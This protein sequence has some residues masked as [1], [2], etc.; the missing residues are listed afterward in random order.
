MKYTLITLAALSGSAFA[1]TFIAANS[2]SSNVSDYYPVNRLISDA[3]GFNY[4]APNPHSGGGG[5][6]WWT[7]AVGSTPVTLTFDFNSPQQIGAVGIWDYA[8][9]S[10]SDWNIKLF[11][12]S[13]GTGTA[14]LDQDF[15]LTPNSSNNVSVFNGI[16]LADTAGVSSVVLT[17]RNDGSYG[18]GL[19]EVYFS[20]TTIS[21][22]V[23]EPSSAALL[24]LGGLA[25]ILR[26]RK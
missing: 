7:T 17:A 11:S 6:S 18:S 3:N 26:R 4:S 24:G 12:G 15:S 20:N 21:A 8:S 16:D 22:P 2:V 13:N 19:S 14:L 23:P 25:L 10:P 9:Y 1:Q 5:T